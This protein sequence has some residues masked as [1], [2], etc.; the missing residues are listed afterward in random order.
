MSGAV[1]MAKVILRYDLPLW[2]AGLLTNWMPDNRWTIRLRGTLFR[3]FI[4][5]CGKNFTLAKNVQLKGTDKLEIG[6]G[7]YFASGVWLNAMGGM[8]IEDEVVLSPYVVISTGDH[9]FKDGSVQGGG[10]VMAP[11]RIGRGAWLAAHAVISAGVTVGKSVL[12]GANAVVTKDVPDEVF[13]AGVPAKVVGPRSA[14]P[15]PETEVKHSRF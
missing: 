9:V 5:R 6:D 11:V 14:G 10:V 12:V 2:F 3:P 15:S 13:V 1:K 4:Y 7:V 8:V